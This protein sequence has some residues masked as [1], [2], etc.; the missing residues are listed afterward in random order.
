MRKKIPYGLHDIYDEDIEAVV[1]ILKNGP[2]TQGKTV[3]EFGQALADYSGAK[4]GVAVSSGTAA[5]HISA[6]ALDIGPGDEVI[7]TPMTFCGTSN[8]ILYQGGKV[9]F[10]DIDE[11]TLNI[12]SSLIEEKIT[13]R[14]KAILPVDF[15][16]HPADL[17]EIKSIADKYS[18]KIIE[19]GSHSIGSSYYLNG[20]EYYCGDGI[21]ADLC[22]Y[23]FHPVKHI[24]TGEGGAVL[25]ND[26]NLFDKVFLLRK[27]GLDRKKEMFSEEK[28]IGSWM[29]EMEDLGFNYRIT[30]FQAALGLSQLK[31]INQIKARRREIVN[32]YNESFS[33]IDELILPHEDQNVDSNFHLYILQ[34]KDNAKF[35]RYDLFTYLQSKDYQPMV[36][37]IPVH[38]LGYYRKLY[39]HKRG[40]FP[41]SENFYDRAVS[42]PLYPALTD[43]EIEKVVEDIYNFVGSL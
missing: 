10:V 20:K 39:N 42:I 3:E 19:D 25:T 11:K 9:K 41:I 29:Y 4:Y 34:V 27:H 28:R 37:Y 31:K 21:H 13:E 33:N 26:P 30:D 40:D 8:A 22:T 2:I 18:L 7:T 32:Y 15:R 17:V 36:H 35:D 5:L 6:V 38:L 14:T 23:S 43:L 12:N 24:T 1:D 16:G